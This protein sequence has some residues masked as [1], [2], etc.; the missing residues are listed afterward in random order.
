[1][2][3]KQGIR[4][5]TGGKELSEGARVN[6]LMR[7]EVLVNVYLFDM[8]AAMTRTPIPQTYWINKAFFFMMLRGK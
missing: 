7:D 6:I 1:M 4:G 3:V 8:G 2:D 5:I